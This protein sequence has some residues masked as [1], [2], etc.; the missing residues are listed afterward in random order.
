[1]PKS[2]KKQREEADLTAQQAEAKKLSDAKLLEG[3][4]TEE[5]EALN[6]E[7]EKKEVKQENKQAVNIEGLSEETNKL[8][9]E[10]TGKKEE[11]E[12]TA[13]PVEKTQA[14]V[15]LTPEQQ[16]TLE[17]LDSI[18]ADP[19]KSV[20]FNALKEGKLFDAL[21][22]YLPKGEDYSALKPKELLERSLIVDGA[23]KEEIEKELASFDDLSYYEKGKIKIE[24]LEIL[25][26]KNPSISPKLIEKL[27]KQSEQE[28]QWKQVLSQRES[29]AAKLVESE[30]NSLIGKTINGIPVTKENSQELSELIVASTPKVKS[31]Q[32]GYDLDVKT[33]IERGKKVFAYDK[34]IAEKDKRIKALETLAKEFLDREEK[35]ARPSKHYVSQP[36][37]RDARP[38]IEKSSTSGFNW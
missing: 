12:E 7:Q 5:I 20:L 23:S 36:L 28:K 10:L 9:S 18:M 37:G 19:E 13:I 14:E 17:L 30:I 8:I 27:Q 15:K 22:E 2:I 33:G 38:V 6:K 34:V 21:T 29:N 4:S 3:K 26:K 32:G 35:R 24:A 16:S 31:P 11:V 1:M 25:N